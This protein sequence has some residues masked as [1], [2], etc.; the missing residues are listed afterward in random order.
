MGGWL[1][2]IALV[3]QTL[4]PFG[5]GIP[6]SSGN[7]LEQ[8]LLFHCEVMK[9][10]TTP[11]TPLPA[12][13]QRSNCV[14]CVACAIGSSLITASAVATLSPKTLYRELVSLSAVDI[15]TGQS[16]SQ[17]TARSPPVIA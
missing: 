13:D 4:I 16:P 2:V 11:A 17:T 1:G 9:A 5:Q 12:S 10:G 15:A 3:V 8:A 14:V 6:V 7:S